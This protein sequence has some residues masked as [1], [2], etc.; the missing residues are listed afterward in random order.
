[1]SGSCSVPGSKPLCF[2]RAESH[3][4]R[5]ARHCLASGDGAFGHKAVAL[6]AGKPALFHAMLDAGFAV[7]RVELRDPYV[8]VLHRANADPTLSVKFELRDGRS[9]SLLELDELYL[10][11]A[12]RFARTADAPS[13]ATDLVELW[14]ERNSAIRER[15]WVEGLARDYDGPMKI[16][17]L[18]QAAGEM[19]LAW[20]AVAPAYD[21]WLQLRHL[22]GDRA[23]LEA[24]L[25]GPA[26]FFSRRR[27]SPRARQWADTIETIDELAAL[28]V[29]FLSL[30]ADGWLCPF[31]Q[32]EQQ[33]WNRH[34][35]VSRDL[36][37]RARDAQE[38][39]PGNGTRAELRSRLIR[40]LHTNGDS[41]YCDW[42]VISSERSGEF[43][44][45]NPFASTGR[46]SAD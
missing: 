41:A 16:K 40:E 5:G 46:W 10:A 11:D 28:D 7:S 31:D 14:H 25:S 23:R 32:L 17:A 35:L 24:A 44:M 22:I 18:K 36:V 34:R 19:G 38:P 39:L 8:E 21:T 45:Q 33:G 3:A 2:F 42:T 26:G 1:M 43:Q 15:G 30:G 13:W 29:F 27:Q 37:Q 12:R 20:E 6:A 9:V 4:H